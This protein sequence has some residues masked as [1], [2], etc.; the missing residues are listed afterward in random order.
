MDVTGPT[1][2][3]E[4]EKRAA[5]WFDS[6]G[7][8]FEWLAERFPATSLGYTDSS[9]R[10]LLADASDAFEF[11]ERTPDD[12][13]PSWYSEHSGIGYARLSTASLWLV[14]ALALYEGDV[15]ITR[16]P[17]RLQWGVHHTRLN[18]QEWFVHPA[19]VGYRWPY[20][21]IEDMA[22]FAVR[23][24]SSQ[25]EDPQ[26]VVAAINCFVSIGQLRSWPPPSEAGLPNS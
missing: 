16:D 19:V 1:G 13:L 5:D 2:S 21:T 22:L 14:D 25:P 8:K 10:A 18:S 23:A 3:A 20:C 24:A 11:A 17:L 7:R 4:A 15:I 26:H 9:L 12:E 6:A